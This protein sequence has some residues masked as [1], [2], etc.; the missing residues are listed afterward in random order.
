MGTGKNA[1]KDCA[2][3]IH[4]KEDELGKSTVV[5]HLLINKIWKKFWWVDKLNVTLTAIAHLI[6]RVE[7]ILLTGVRKDQPENHKGVVTGTSWDVICWEVGRI[8]LFKEKN[9]TT[10]QNENRGNLWLL[11][12][13][14]PF[15]KINGGKRSGE[16]NAKK[17]ETCDEAGVPWLDADGEIVFALAE[18]LVAVRNVEETARIWCTKL[19]LT[20]S[21]C[22]FSNTKSLEYCN[23]VKRPHGSDQKS[24]ILE[25]GWILRPNNL[26][27]IIFVYPGALAPVRIRTHSGVGL[28]HRG[29]VESNSL[30]AKD[31]PCLSASNRSR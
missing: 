23:R 31:T 4:P 16:E 15:R 26:Q 2:K 13:H 11:S 8:W 21:L 14:P 29:Q 22:R 25:C 5:L 19:K 6:E 17:M 28:P 1:P 10:N 24:L 20:S 18:V 7:A 27:L 12:A 30:G 3:K 9:G